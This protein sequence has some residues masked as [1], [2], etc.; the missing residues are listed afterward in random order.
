MSIAEE[1]TMKRRVLGRY[2]V[3]DPKICHGKM[4]FRGTRVFVSDIL[5]DVADG[6]DW[7]VIVEKWHR[8]FPKAAIAEAVRLASEAMFAQYEPSAALA[9]RS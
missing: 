4:T 7:G 9:I 1:N 2:L 8:S 6:L 5:E 3:V